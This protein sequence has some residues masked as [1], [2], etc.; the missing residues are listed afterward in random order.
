MNKREKQNSHISILLSKLEE[1]TI[2]I[3]V[4]LETYENDFKD[5]T[6]NTFRKKN[7]TRERVIRI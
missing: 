4:L 2:D 1:K 5:T 7:R 6:K 3:D